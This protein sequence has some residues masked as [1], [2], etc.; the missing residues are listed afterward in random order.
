[1][2]THLRSKG[3]GMQVVLIVG[4]MLVGAVLALSLRFLFEEKFTLFFSKYFGGLTS[5][6]ARRLIGLWYSVFWYYGVDKKI[7]RHTHVLAFRTVGNR[8]TATTVAGPYIKYQ[9]FAK[10]TSSIYITGTWENA[11]SDNIYHGA[12]QF[13]LQPEGNVQTGRWVGWNKDQAVGAGPWILVRISS[14]V[15]EGAIES[16]RQ[17]VVTPGAANMETVY[18]PDI[19]KVIP[20]HVELQRLREA[21][22]TWHNAQEP[23][24]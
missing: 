21:L 24:A 3:G 8:V 23:G 11:T 19:E 4:Q 6:R 22:A 9:M 1:M 14:D 13:V 20:T 12:C 18:D 17:R 15:G 5:K 7:H 2:M 10:L 16:V